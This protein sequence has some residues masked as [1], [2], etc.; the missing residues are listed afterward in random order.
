L[1]QKG[2]PWW[3]FNTF[4]ISNEVTVEELRRRLA[5]SVQSHQILRSIFIGQGTEK[6]LQVVLKKWEIPVFYVDLSRLALSEEKDGELSDSQ[7]RYLVNLKQLY[8]EKPFSSSKV[9]F[10]TGLI[11]ISKNKSILVLVDSHILLDGVGRTRIIEE[12]AGVVTPVSDVRQY[13]RYLCHILSDSYKEESRKVWEKAISEKS[14]LTELLISPR[15]VRGRKM[16]EFIPGKQLIEKAK[17]FCLNM[18]ITL[19]TLFSLA[20]G[21]V[22]MELCGT[23]EAGFVS[24][25]SGRDAE[26]A[27]LTGMFSVGIP[28]FIKKGDTPATVQEQIVSAMG[29]LLP[30]M[31]D[32]GLSL[33]DSSSKYHVTLSMQIFQQHHQKTKEFEPFFLNN[34]ALYRGIPLKPSPAPIKKLTILV[35][36]EYLFSINIVYDGQYIEDDFVKK[37]GGSLITQLKSLIE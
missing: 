8:E 23:E 15:T 20:L 3:V 9:M 19:S 17:R 2:I 21:R 26:N 29:R 33:D 11:K 18:H 30:D 37:L 31:D 34:M 35:I 6:P 27:E 32:L 22:L 14:R 7:I 4:L 10:E 12:I 16:R 36:P 25:N 24:I 5:A 13:N 28:L 1:V